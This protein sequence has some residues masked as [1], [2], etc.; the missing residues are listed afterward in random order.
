L[1]SAQAK[2]NGIEVV[3]ASGLRQPSEVRKELKEISQQLSEYKE[4][5]KQHQ[6]L[7]HRDR[8][9]R[10]AWKHGILGIE[11]ADAQ[12]NSVFYQGANE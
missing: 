1:K 6:F 9:M 2:L 8:V 4:F 11:D 10:T 5:K 12:N 3:K 7:G